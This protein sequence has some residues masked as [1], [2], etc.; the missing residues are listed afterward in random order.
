VLGLSLFKGVTAAEIEAIVDGSDKK[1]FASTHD[2]A[3]ACL[4]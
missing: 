1:R 4:M 3:R 2:P